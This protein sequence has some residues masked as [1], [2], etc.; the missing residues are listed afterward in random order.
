MIR[1]QFIKNILEV[2]L[3]VVCIIGIAM[4][5]GQW[6][7]ANYFKSLNATISSLN[8]KYAKTNQ[9]VKSINQKLAQLEFIQNAYSPA[10][11]L[12]PEIIQAI[13]NGVSLT[14]LNLNPKSKQLNMA[15]FAATRDDFLDMQ[16]RIAKIPWIQEWD[17]PVDQLTK[18]DNINFSFSATIK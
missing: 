5:G 15:G 7:L 14:A 8:N 9:T 1:F 3:I 4:L 16:T 18:K 10:A 6:V 17:V 11:P 13:P 12:L 2:I